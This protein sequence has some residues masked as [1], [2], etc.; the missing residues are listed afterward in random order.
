MAKTRSRRGARRN[1]TR[2]GGGKGS[3]GMDVERSKVHRVK[4]KSMK[5]GAKGKP[6]KKLTKKEIIAFIEKRLAEIPNR[7]EPYVINSPEKSYPSVP[8]FSADV[9]PPATSVAPTPPAAT[10]APA[11]PATS[12]APAPV[13]P[14]YTTNNKEPFNLSKLEKALGEKANNNSPPPPTAMNNNS[15]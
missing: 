13:A 15:K 11:P 5:H 6:K 12:A 7:N 8:N 10:I 3:R 4:G 2:R 9:A 14:F 1:I